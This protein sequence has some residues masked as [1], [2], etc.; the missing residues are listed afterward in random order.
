M[1]ELSPNAHE[2]DRSSLN[3]VLERNTVVVARDTS[4]PSEIIIGTATLVIMD[5]LVGRRGRVEDVV[6][7]S[8]YRRRGIGRGLMEEL[9][10][11]AIHAG[12]FKLALSSRIENDDASE[13]YRSLGYTK[14]HLEI[15]T[16]DLAKR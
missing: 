11:Q 16:I 2:H 7:A 15:Y 14:G 12:V 1:H 3:R 13:F 4:H 9:R 6:V 10:R 5:Q 8:G